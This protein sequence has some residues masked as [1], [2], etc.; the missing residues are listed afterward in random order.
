MLK[1]KA[2]KIKALFFAALILQILQIKSAQAATASCSGSIGYR[3]EKKISLY[4]DCINL[5][6]DIKAYEE[7]IFEDQVIL[8]T[9]SY[10]ISA[11]NIK[12]SNGGVLN[13]GDSSHA[14]GTIKANLD[15]AENGVGTLNFNRTKTTDAGF[16][17][18]QTNKLANINIADAATVTL[19]GG[20]AA[21]NININGTLK[22]NGVNISANNI[23][24]AN[25][26][27]FNIAADSEIS[28]AINAVNAGDGTVQFSKA[29]EIVEARN[30]DESVG[31]TTKL[32]QILISNDVEVNIN[33]NIIFNADNITIGEG[34]PSQFEAPTLNQ[35]NGVIG[36][37][38]NSLIRLNSGSVF[39][40]NGGI[41][42]GTIRGTSSN[43]GTFNVNHNYTN[44]FEIG[45]SYDLANLNVAYNSVL[46]ANN[47]ISAN[48]IN[49]A[50]TLDLGNSSKLITGNLSTS[51]NAA[52]I[53]L[54][55]IGHKII[56]NFATSAGDVLKVNAV[57]NTQIGK[58]NVSGVAKI[59]AGLG[60]KIYLDTQKSYFSNNSKITLI[61]AGSGS[62]ISS[63]KAENI[64]VNQTGSNQY[65]LL[66]F[67]TSQ[68][69]NDLILTVHRKEAETFSSRQSVSQIYKN[70]DQIGSSASGELRDLQK[71]VDSTATNNNQK[72]SALK[73]TIPQNSQDLNNSSF[74]VANAAVGV[75]QNRMQNTF[76]GSSGQSSTD[77][78]QPKMFK[79]FSNS[80]LKSSSLNHSSFNNNS[81]NKNIN[82]LSNLG[83]GNEKLFDEQIFDNQALWVQGFS[84]SGTQ[85]NVGEIDGYNLLNQG[86]AIGIDQEV[87][88]DLRL[89]IST[90]F[91]SSNIKS[92][93]NN[94]RET[95]VDSYQFNFYGGYNFAP[96]FVSSVIGVALNRYD[97]TR[98]MK[99]MG[100]QAKANY[101][102][103]TYITKVEGGMTK[104]Y[105]SGLTL[106]PKISL[107][108]ARNQVQTYQEK[109]AGTLNLN[110]S[111]QNGDFLEGRIGGDLICNRLKAAGWSLKPK[112]KTSFGYNFLSGK[113]SANNHF[114]GQEFGFKTT[115]SNVD[116]TSLK[117]GLAVDMYNN[118]D[119]LLALDYEIEQKKSYKSSTSSVY[120]RYAF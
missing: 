39:N 55:S 1:F 13:Y 11:T 37:D 58:L 113:Q 86:L 56:G 35:N 36:A 49:I 107:T 92:K 6:G 103:E 81:T 102:G 96:Y 2:Y 116:K 29:A 112:V 63:I 69:A 111:N 114:Q 109:G 23:N 18:G 21:T 52:V 46:T 98:E 87:A 110:I 100:L 64:D 118:A 93:S 60:L 5:A 31:K 41:I 4:P 65:G 73:S 17:V 78:L 59:D 45:K 95:N 33:Q 75:T 71:L 84:T 47:N 3:N 91:A 99:E 94:L 16:L 28:G 82:I 20:I 25:G 54:G 38:E 44:N 9:G 89:G 88:K 120:L 104:N 90:S 105:D 19:K 57:N 61:S 30:Q 14:A 10:N 34:S 68:V 108:A 119:I 79:K 72:E 62:N 80:L 12:I 27:I 24:L 117:Y 7:I 76:F 50:G 40:Y 77:F 8:N 42:N 32:G 67:S 70:I 97:S 51:G 48:N 83:F 85:A 74:S 106:S 53:N 43:K 101:G 22:S 66:T 115:S 15:G 26:A